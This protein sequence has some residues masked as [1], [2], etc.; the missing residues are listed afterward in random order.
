MNREKFCEMLYIAKQESG[1]STSELSFSLKMLLPALRRFEKGTH[2]FSVA[3]CIEY[4]TA[5]RH[6][7]SLTGKDGS[8]NFYQYDDLLAYIVEHRKQCGSLAK[9]AETIGISKQGLSNIEVKRSIMS[10]DIL[11]SLT[12][13][14][15]V[16]IGITPI[17]N[18]I[19]QK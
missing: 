6:C 17:T 12:N 19:L 10:I 11:I 15:D 13:V 16:Q 3:R 4:L 7:L 18:S 1:M 9:V 5:I 8:I 14:F 2:N